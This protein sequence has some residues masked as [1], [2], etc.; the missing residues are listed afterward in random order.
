MAVVCSELQKSRRIVS[1]KSA[2]FLYVVTGTNS[3]TAALAAVLAASAET[4]TF[5]APISVTL[6]RQPPEIDPVW[7]SDADGMWE[8]RV[9]YQD[10]SRSDPP[11]Q[12]NES[13]FSFDTT[14]GSQ[15]LTQ[16]R[17]TAGKYPETAEDYG[18]AIGYDGERLEG[19]DITTPCFKFSET[20]YK[21]ASF[22]DDD[23]KR[24]V[25][26]LTGKVN[27]AVFKGH[28]AG[29]VLFLGVTGS[30]RG[31]KPE[32]LWEL[33]YSFAVSENETNLTVGTGAGAITGISKEGW[34]YLWVRYEE[35]VDSTAK[36]KVK[37]P[38]AVY[39]ENV[40]RKANFSGLEIG[41]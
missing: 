30:R 40:Y 20:H 38:K 26:L 15:H 28:E 29:E 34:Q 25:K 9:Q 33:T 14:G 17:S 13:S 36:V 4:Y 11:P 24:L 21:A 6:V 19:C 5:A 1:G 8:A 41:T 27:N 22:V 23:Y 2:E 7:V 35:S 12:E 10:D 39:I 37:K 3:E 18:G 32:D 31:R 16:S